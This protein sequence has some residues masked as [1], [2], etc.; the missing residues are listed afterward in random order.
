VLRALGLCLLATLLVPGLCGVGAAADQAGFR[1]AVVAGG[2]DAFMEVRHVVIEGTNV[3]IGQKIAELARA[4]GAEMQPSADP[5][6]T[7]VQRRYIQENYPILYDRMRGLAEGFA[8]DINDDRYDFSALLFVPSVRPG[9]SVVYYPAGN[10]EA[11]RDMLSRNYDFTTGDLQGRSVGPSQLGCMAR[12]Y[13]LELHPDKGY[14]SL[15]IC[16]FEF[17]AGVL[18]GINSQGLAVAILA[19]D[20]TIRS[21]GLEPTRGVGMHE[22][23]SMR[24]LLDNC[25]DV[26][27]A[28]EALLSLKHFY[29]FIPCHYIV[30]DSSGRSFIFEFNPQR[31]R[32]GLVDGAGP[33]CVTNH[34]VSTRGSVEDLPAGDS[35]DRFRALRRST[36]SSPRM[37]TEQII[38][39]NAAVAVPPE[40]P[41]DPR[42]A[43]GRTLWYSLYDLDRRVLR[44]RFYLGERPDPSSPG[45]ALLDYSDFLEFKLDS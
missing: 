7:R 3:Q 43:P 33:Q 21:E 24:Y 38:D 18:D 6:V 20:E 10:T 42:Y 30:G 28:K 23:A 1:Q 8:M 44:V 5:L 34:L 9:C 31:N 27:E 29:S 32:V 22:L 15:A 17:V 2:P 16:T 13:V 19:D 45:M 11:G 39:A 14:A 4:A 40:L 25:K 36:T 35:Y 26:P 41:G 37:T 12:P